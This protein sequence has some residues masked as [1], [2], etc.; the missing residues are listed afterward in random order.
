MNSPQRKNKTKSCTTAFAGTVFAFVALFVG[1]AIPAQAQIPHSYRS[2][3]VSGCADR[4]SESL[5]C[6]GSG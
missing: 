2:L 5:W 1:L 6:H 4:R 3:R